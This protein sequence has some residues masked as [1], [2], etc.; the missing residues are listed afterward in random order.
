MFTG[1]TNELCLLILR[2][3]CLFENKKKAKDVADKSRFRQTWTDRETDIVMN[4]VSIT[5][6]STSLNSYIVIDLIDS[7]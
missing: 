7:Y 6:K 2:T 5:A 3:Y 1:C 4:R